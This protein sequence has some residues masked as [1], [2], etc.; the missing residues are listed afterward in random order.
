MIE[1]EYSK[2]VKDLDKYIN[3]CEKNNYMFKEKIKQKRIIYRK[4]DNTIARITINE[5][6]NKIY[7]Y[8][9]FKESKLNNELN[10]RKESKELE[11]NDEK[12]IYSILDFL[13]YKKDNTLERIRYVYIKENITFELDK[14]TKPKI[15]NV[16]SVEGKKNIVDKV[17]EEVKKI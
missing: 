1:Y 7:K 13:G 10:I 15:C 8:L 14:Y 6:D 2:N 12:I 4:N 16:L 9:D 17:W 5:I 3:Y 11:F